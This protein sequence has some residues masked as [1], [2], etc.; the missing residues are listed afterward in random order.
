MPAS[1]LSTPAL[2]WAVASFNCPAPVWIAEKPFTTPESVSA[3][4]IWLIVETYLFKPAEN[5]DEPAASTSVPF[6]LSSPVLF[7]SF[8]VFLAYSFA[9]FASVF[10][11]SA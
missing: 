7:T 10:V 8:F 6:V 11:P 1:K 4:K 9:L 3:D 5:C 2:N